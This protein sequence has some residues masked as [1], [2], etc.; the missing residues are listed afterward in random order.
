MPKQQPTIVSSRLLQPTATSSSRNAQQRAD[1]ASSL[2]SVAP[3]N[4][5][6][7]LHSSQRKRVEKDYVAAV[8]ATASAAEAADAPDTP[9]KKSVHFPELPSALKQPSVHHEH[10]DGDAPQ[11]QATPASATTAVAGPTP[12]PLSPAAAPS[13]SY[14]RGIGNAKEAAT[15]RSATDLL[16]SPVSPWARGFLSSRMRQ[17]SRTS[18]SQNVHAAAAFHRAENAARAIRTNLLG[19]QAGDDAPMIVRRV[20]ITDDA[21]MSLLDVNVDGNAVPVSVRKPL[22]NTYTFHAAHSDGCAADSIVSAVVGAVRFGPIGAGA[23]SHESLA[24][25]SATEV[26]KFRRGAEHREDESAVAAVDAEQT[27]KQKRREDRRARF[28]DFFSLLEENDTDAKDPHQAALEKRLTSLLSAAR[29]A[30]KAHIA[31]ARQ[32]P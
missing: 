29:D 12:P 18:A 21:A 30:T 31:S 14:M 2:P 7:Q 5:Q 3:A 15:A 4:H 24:R 26:R 22:A 19:L 9:R 10:R 11:V 32:Q 23:P 16:L 20:D 28:D 1:K 17:D 8:V 27:A 13:P 6:R 25:V